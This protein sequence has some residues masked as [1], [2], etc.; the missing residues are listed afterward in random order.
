MRKVCLPLTG[1][2]AHLPL[3]VQI[4]PTQ[5]LVEPLS[6]LLPIA[7]QFYKKLKYEHQKKLKVK[8]E[9]L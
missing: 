2:K 8:P 1:L 3:Q 4:L 9:N 6:P 5:S 7:G